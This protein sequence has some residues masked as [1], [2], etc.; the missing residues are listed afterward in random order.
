MKFNFHGKR[1]SRLSWNPSRTMSDKK[2]YVLG[3]GI[4]QVPLS[5][6]RDECIRGGKSNLAQ[7]RNSDSRYG[8]IEDLNKSDP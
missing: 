7:R 5:K 2:K 1:I 8:G 6:R 4:Y 3:T